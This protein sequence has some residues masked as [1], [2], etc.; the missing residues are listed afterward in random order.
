MIVC[1]CLG[2]AVSA[3]ALAIDHAAKELVGDVRLAMKRSDLSLDY[4]SRVTGVPPQR[5]S[6]QLNGKTPFTAF[7]RFT[8]AEIRETAFWPEFLGI[9]NERCGLVQVPRDLGLLVA[10][11]RELVSMNPVALAAT[12]DERKRA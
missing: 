3:S 4:V 7:W 6:D 1:L 10:S 11:V 8:R 2:L 9:R 5:L 12:A